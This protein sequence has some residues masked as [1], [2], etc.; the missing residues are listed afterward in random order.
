MIIPCRSGNIEAEIS[1]RLIN[2]VN[3]TCAASNPLNLPDGTFAI[4]AADRGLPRSR[5]RA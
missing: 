5:E 4:A 3:P 2:L 1:F